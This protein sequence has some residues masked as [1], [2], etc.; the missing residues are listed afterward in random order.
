VVL[1]DVG[2]GAIVGAGAVVTHPVPDNGVAVGVPARV[3]RFRSAADAE[4]AR[5]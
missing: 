2:R 5:V 1:A 4:P 3:V